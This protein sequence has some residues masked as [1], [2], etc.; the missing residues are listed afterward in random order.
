MSSTTNSLT[1]VF[2]RIL[3]YF[4]EKMMIQED[5]IELE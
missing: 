2:A 3:P 5:L 4:Q 1:D